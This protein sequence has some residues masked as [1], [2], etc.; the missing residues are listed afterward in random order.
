MAACSGCPCSSRWAH[1]CADTFHSSLPT[2]LHRTN[3]PRTHLLSQR[4][5]QLFQSWWLKDIF[6]WRIQY[7]SIKKKEFP[8]CQKQPTSKNIYREDSI[9]CFEKLSPLQLSSIME[10]I[11]Q[12]GQS[13]MKKQKMTW[14]PHTRWRST[15]KAHS[16]SMKSWDGDPTQAITCKNTTLQSQSGAADF[17]DREQPG[18]DCTVTIC[19][20]NHHWKHMI[21]FEG[22][23]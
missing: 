7:L 9:G 21:D 22:S 16:S 15:G 13:Q 6:W 2:T 1:S 5:N 20:Y 23:F 10:R 17:T 11:A 19:Y 14:S 12:T 3:S 4:W 18:W 8:M